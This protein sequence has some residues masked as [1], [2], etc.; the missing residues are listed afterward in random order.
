MSI[1]LCCVVFDFIFFVFFLVGLLKQMCLAV[2]SLVAVAVQ[3]APSPDPAYQVVPVVPSYQGK[4]HAQDEL[5]QYSFGHHEPNQVRHESKD[6]AGVVRGSYRYGRRSSFLR[7][8]SIRIPVN[9][10][11]AQTDWQSIKSNRLIRVSSYLGADGATVTNHYIADEN[12][13]RSS[14]APSNGPVLPVTGKISGVPVTGQ[15]A[16]NS[17]W[18]LCQSKSSR[19]RFSYFACSRSLKK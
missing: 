6:A 17:R 2:L 13:F 12:G 1:H 19:V 14:L 9:P 11:K 3:A 5:G 4:Y 7:Y 10:N 15:S 8:Q 16:W 18:W